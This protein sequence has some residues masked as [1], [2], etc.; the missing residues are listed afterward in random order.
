MA[1]CLL[2]LIFI[3]QV[4]FPAD[5]PYID[6]AKKVAKWLSSTAIQTPHGKVWAADPN[7]STTITTNLYSGSAGIVLFFLEMYHSTGD[8]QYL[9]EAQ[10][11]ADKLLDVVMDTDQVRE[12]DYGLYTGVA[13]LGFTLGE[14]YAVTKDTRYRKGFRRCA[15]LIRGNAS[16]SGNGVAWMLHQG[17]TTY[18]VTD[19]IS[20]SSGIGLFLLYASHHLGDLRYREAGVQAGHCLI[21]AGQQVPAGMKW[22]M[23][24]KVPELSPL[25]R[26]LMPN[27]SHGTA[28]I[29]FFLATLYQETN[30]KI[31]LDAAEA[32]A[33]YLQSVAMTDSGIACVFHNEPD[34]RDLFYLGWC[35][36]P[37]GTARLFYRLKQITGD[38]M[39]MRWVDRFARTEIQ[40]GI[41]ENRTPGFWNNVGQCCGSAGIAEFFLD[42]YAVANKKVHLDFARRITADLLKRATTDNAGMRWIQ[43]EHRVRPDL[44]IAQTGYM[45][46]AAGIGML[47][48]HL[49]AWEQGKRGRI[50]FPDS[51][52]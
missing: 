10:A 19:I 38:R 40:N 26:R 22:A 33:R 35:H 41:P 32:G 46:G 9:A 42:L 31:F 29:A 4:A 30:E 13:G 39:W 48:L 5:R 6:A 34:N 45:Q 15:E 2:L 3:T 20:G 51:P 17:D 37:P 1:R 23:D 44:L 7:D 50:V 24:A 27:F 28:G 8:S 18:F 49:D 43:A 12:M 47:L 11:G 16:P 36:G 21:E 14:V 52:F 25:Y